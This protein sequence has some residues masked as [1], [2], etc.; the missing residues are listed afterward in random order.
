MADSK[1]PA[2]QYAVS[3]RPLPGESESG[4]SYAVISRPRGWLVAVIDGLG[5]GPQAAFAA[6]L[7]VTTLTS[8]AHLPLLDLVKQCHE[9]LLRT[10][11]VVMSIASLESGEGSMTWVSVGNVAGLLLRVNDFGNLE[12]EHVVMRS[13]VVGHRLPP[14]RTTTMGLVRGDLLV[15][16]TDGIREGFQ[17]DVRPD[18]HPQETAAHILAQ[19]ARP[20]DDALVLVGRWR[21]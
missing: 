17:S 19:H 4:D 9:A 6:K 15:F 1:V 13:G 5:H 14:L 8:H 2:F 20:T 7:T 10:R 18:A 3:S 11:G 12:R 16:A 21:G